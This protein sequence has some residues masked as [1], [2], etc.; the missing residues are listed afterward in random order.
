MEILAGYAVVYLIGWGAGFL[1]CTLV[2][3]YTAVAAAKK[4][5]E[6]RAQV[7]DLYPRR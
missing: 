6:V 3:Y 7:K 1:T 4:P 5:V 2:V